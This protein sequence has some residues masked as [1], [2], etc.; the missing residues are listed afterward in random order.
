MSPLRRSHTAFLVLALAVLSCAGCRSD[1]AAPRREPDAHT[2]PPAGATAAGLDPATWT[3]HLEADLMPYWLMAEAQ[4]TPAGNFPTFRGMDGT[5]QGS[6][7]RRPRMLGRQVY[8]YCTAFLMTGDERYLDLARAGTAWLLDKAWDAE[9]GGW[10]AELDATG[11][12]LAPTTEAKLAQDAAYSAMGPAAYFF[13]TR[14]PGAEA[15]VLATRDLLFDPATYWDAENRRI[16][17]GVNADLTEPR[18]QDVDDGWELVAQLDPVTAFLLLVQPVLTEPARRAQALSD[19]ETLA[20]TMEESFW[21]DDMFF[22]ATDL[23]GDYGTHH[24]DFGHAL[25]AYWALLQIDKRLDDHPFADFVAEGAPALLLRAY[26]PAYGRW[27]ERPTSKTSVAYG[28]AW[29]SYAESDQLAATLALHD[30]EW[31]DELGET[32]GHFRED[33]VDDTRAARELVPNI[34]RN[35]AWGW[36]WETTDTA[37][38]NEWKNG[39]H[40]AEHA[41]VLY[42]FSHWRAGTAAPLYFAFP[43]E[44]AQALAEEARPYTFLGRVASVD[45]LGAL[46]SDPTRRKVRVSFDELR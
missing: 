36:T 12:P 25:K 27:A 16:R 24:T 31:I 32:A 9:R 19:L 15:A 20:H 8:T 5:I 45:D 37:K 26:D 35:G 11:A 29:W 17:D 23:V 38:C 3:A 40:G 22:G 42:L 33:F 2:P 28:N 41:L 14:D 4:G 43:A 18:V 13:V 39:F 1:G 44:T 21:A 30:P 6:S 7:N 10:H 34:R 46:A